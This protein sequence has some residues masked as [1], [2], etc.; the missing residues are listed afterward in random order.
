MTTPRSTGR[1]AGIQRV[2]EARP[3]GTPV[4]LN[5]HAG[6][7][8]QRHDRMPTLLS[9]DSGGGGMWTSCRDDLAISVRIPR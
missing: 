5:H 4:A 1:T 6:R 3:C 9:D 8:A 2:P 7:V